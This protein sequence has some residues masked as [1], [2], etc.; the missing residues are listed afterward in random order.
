MTSDPDTVPRPSRLT[1]RLIPCGLLWL[2]ALLAVGQA[3]VPSAITGDGTL[4]TTVTQSGTIHTITGGTRP[5]NGP[6][7]FHSF[8][9]F[10]VGTGD[11]ARFSGPTGIANILSRVTGGHQSIIDG[12]LQSTIPGA[13]LYLLNPSGVLFGPNASLD[14]RGSF[15]VSTAD[16]L[17]FGDG[18]TFAANLGQAST[19]TVAEPAAFGFLGS[20]PAPITI[21]GSTLQVPT[22]KALSVVGGDIE[23]V[24]RGPLTPTNVPTLGAPRGRIQLASVAAPGE[25][26]FSPLELAPDL[27][28]DSFAQLGRIALSQGALLEASGNGGGVVLLRGGHLFVDHAA[29]L[30]DNTGPVDG[31][32]LGLDLGIRADAVIRHGAFLTTDSGDAGRARDLRLT[33]G[34]VHLDGAVIGSRAFAAGDSGH[35]M[36]RVGT[37]TLTGGAQLDS[38]TQAGAAGHGGRLMVTATDA[39]TITGPDSGLVSATLGTGRGRDHRRGQA[40]D[41]HRGCRS[42]EPPSLLE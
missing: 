11:T 1:R 13:N 30:A 34:R 26:G 23:I 9:R 17:R 7:L 20:L 14:I 32:G 42:Q 33:A 22:G 6:N 28:V 8:D 3:A 18:A 29:M 24:G 38:S 5:G 21:Q 35:V 25:V 40:A 10:S 31:V 16:Y 37:L 41:T 39:I 4:G 12:W 15:H 36:V 19:L 2:W 27:Q